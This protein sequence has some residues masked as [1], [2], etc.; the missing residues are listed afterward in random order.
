MGDRLPKN[1]I[2]EIGVEME[3][4]LFFRHQFTY[5]EDSRIDIVRSADHEGKVSALSTH[6]T[7]LIFSM[8]SVQMHGI[9]LKECVFVGY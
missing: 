7:A 4:R 5:F 6:C 9:G 8:I 2:R 1:S 3:N